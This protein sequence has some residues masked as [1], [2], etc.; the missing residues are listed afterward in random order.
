MHVS[1]IGRITELSSKHSCV[2]Q[3]CHCA[4]GANLRRVRR[5]DGQKGKRARA[6]HAC[7]RTLLGRSNQP[8]GQGRSIDPSSSHAL[9]NRSSYQRLGI[10][11][12][13]FPG[14]LQP[15]L[16]CWIPPLRSLR[17]RCFAF[18]LGFFFAF[19]SLSS[20]CPSA[21]RSWPVDTAAVVIL[22]FLHE[23]L[24]VEVNGPL[25]EP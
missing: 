3:I 1:D 18:W 6:A 9:S 12:I 13:V 10:A 16:R 23:I 17:R 14:R 19:V 22:F 7:A 5:I 2:L 4:A 25:C 8:K 11:C 20:L 24:G 21:V 15:H